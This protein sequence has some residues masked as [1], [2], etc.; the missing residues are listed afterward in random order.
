MN[1]NNQ[2]SNFRTPENIEKFK[3]L[4]AELP[5]LW[6]ILVSI[7]EFEKVN[8]F[9]TDVAVLV[10]KLV[11]IRKNTFLNA[12]QRFSEDYVYCSDSEAEEPTQFYPTFK[13]IKYPKKYKVSGSIDE[14]L[15][16]KNFSNHDEF[17][18]GIFRKVFNKKVS[19]SLFKKLLQ[20]KK[21]AI[22]G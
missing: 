19:D 16:F 7:C 21:L 4:S 15:C 17:C 9:P 14:D 22:S 5:A 10:T 20:L 12:S 11:S 3:I 2:T 6:L 1:Q 8:K 18:Y 13:K